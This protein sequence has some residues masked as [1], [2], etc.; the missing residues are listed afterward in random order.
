[1]AV[2]S[3]LHILTDE[4]CEGVPEYIRREAYLAPTACEHWSKAV[5]DELAQG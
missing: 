1:M 3:M 4:L 2:A 5:V